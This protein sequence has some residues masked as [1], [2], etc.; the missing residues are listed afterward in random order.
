VNRG[1]KQIL[2]LRAAKGLALPLVFLPDWEGGV[3]T[4]QRSL[5]EN[6]DKT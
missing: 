5:D 6:G 4:S 2:T 3:F 1:A